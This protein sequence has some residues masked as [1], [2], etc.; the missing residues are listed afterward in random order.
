M[1]A[2]DH[3]L[4]SPL[5]APELGLASPYIGEV[6]RWY[7]PLAWSLTCPGA[8]ESKVIC[9][10]VPIQ[11]WYVCRRNELLT[12]VAKILYCHLLNLATLFF[13]AAGGESWNPPK[14]SGDPAL[15]DE[16]V[17]RTYVWVRALYQSG[18]PEKQNL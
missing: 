12:R 6:Y 3:L 15:V 2:K 5:D 14:S 13:K 17:V 1:K 8:L 9:P 11:R 16:S 4:R 18:S 7:C 10:W